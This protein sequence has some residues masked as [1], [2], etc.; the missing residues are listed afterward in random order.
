MELVFDCFSCVSSLHFLGSRGKRK[1]GRSLGGGGCHTPPW[2][3]II[4]HLSYEV[5]SDRSNVSL[6]TDYRANDN[7]H[8]QHQETEAMRG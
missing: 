4:M 5:F 8:I 3:I 7:I 2:G 6:A 1:E